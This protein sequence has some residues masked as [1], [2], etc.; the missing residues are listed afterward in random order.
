MYT[1]QISGENLQKIGIERS[2]LSENEASHFQ[3]DIEGVTYLASFKICGNY[4]IGVCQ[5]RKDIYS[6]TYK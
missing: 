3:T 6:G 4:E 1:G 5:T 2:A